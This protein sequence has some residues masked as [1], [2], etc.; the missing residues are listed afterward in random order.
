MHSCGR[1]QQSTISMCMSFTDERGYSIT[2]IHHHHYHQGHRR[3]NAMIWEDLCKA[4]VLEVMQREQKQVDEHK[5]ELY[6]LIDI[7]II[8]EEEE[9]KNYCRDDRIAMTGQEEE[10]RVP[11][12][13]EKEE[14]RH[15]G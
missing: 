5:Y 12:E 11:K 9:N 7:S 1:R 13:Y 2:A 6:N 3:Q 10:V 14:K 8:L 4:Q 15:S